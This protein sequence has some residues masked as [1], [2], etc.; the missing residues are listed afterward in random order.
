MARIP[1]DQARDRL[2]YQI[3]VSPL[4][5]SGFREEPNHARLDRAAAAYL[6]LA[7]KV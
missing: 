1:P 7:L 2:R 3:V 5:N 6:F 4:V